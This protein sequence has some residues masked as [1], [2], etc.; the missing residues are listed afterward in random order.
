MSSQRIAGIVLLAVGVV[1]FLVG[2][3]ASESVADQL[4]EFFTG[5][6]TDTTMWYIIGGIAA[7]VAGLL[8]LAVGGR[9]A[10]R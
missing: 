6:F 3:N 1:L 10:L 9:R 2:M 8:L 5:R 7:A 4:S